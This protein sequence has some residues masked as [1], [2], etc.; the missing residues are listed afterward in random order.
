[1]YS[2]VIKIARPV[3]KAEL[4]EIKI[5]AP[6]LTKPIAEL[7]IAE[8]VPIGISVIMNNIFLFK[9]LQLLIKLIINFKRF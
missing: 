9:F 2:S 7:P 1:M 5:P 3:N 8:P 6:G 4:L